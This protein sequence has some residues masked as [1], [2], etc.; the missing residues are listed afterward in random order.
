VLVKEVNTKNEYKAQYNSFPLSFLQ[1]YEWGQ[2]KKPEWKPL[3]ISIEGYPLTILIRKIPLLN[4]YIAY[5]PRPTFSPE[6]DVKILTKLLDYLESKKN[7]THLEID[8]SCL[9]TLENKNKYSQLNFSSSGEQYQLN[10]TNIIDISKG[11]DSIW[12][13]LDSKTR[14]KIRKPEKE[15]CKIEIFESGK[16]PLDRFYN[17]MNS[18]KKETTYVMHSKEY[19]QKVWEIMSKANMAVIIILSL[20]DLDLGG[21]FAI[22]NKQTLSEL[23]GG[24][25]R[26]GKNIRGAGYFLKWELIKYAFNNNIKTYDQWGV[27]SLTKNG[28]YNQDSPLYYISQ[29]KKEF[30]GKHVSYLPKQTYVFNN[31]D[32]IFFKIAKIPFSFSLYL[33]KLFKR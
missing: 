22:K 33:R 12:E 20:N 32:Y 15:G 23:Y 19:F 16:E 4:K 17:I 6:T 2:V 13:S 31:I 5:I 10:D 21:Y 3:R 18:I 26:K 25:N 14:N 9:N 30:K 24:L 27:S 11:L 1:S 8:P 29:F 7:I 28:Q